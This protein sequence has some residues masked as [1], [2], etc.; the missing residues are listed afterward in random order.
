MTPRFSLRDKVLLLALA[1]AVL[2]AAAFIWF[3]R[4]QLTQD[5]GALLLSESRERITQV[6]LQLGAEL[7]RTAVKDRDAMLE[8]YSAKHGVTFRLFGRDGAQLAGPPAALPGEFR[9]HFESERARTP[10]LDSPQNLERLAEQTRGLRAKAR[11]AI[12]A[13]QAPVDPYLFVVRDPPL[14]VY[15]TGAYWVALRMP[16]RSHDDDTLDL[17]QVVLST[18]SFFGTPFFFH[19]TPWLILLA[20]VVVII[21]VCWLPLVRGVN[22]AIATLAGATSKIAKGDFSAKVD[23]RRSDELGRLGKS[24]NRMSDQLEGYVHGQKRFLRDAAHEL[25]SPLGRMQAALGNIHES[26]VSPEVH[27]LLEDLGEEIE[28][29]SS[30][31]SDLLAFAREEAAAARLHIV[32]VDLQAVA[33]RAVARENPDGVRDVRVHV[34]EGLRVLAHGESLFRGLSNAVRNAIRNAGDAGPITLR[35]ARNE[36]QTLVT[37]S[38]HGPGLP[39]EAL[40]MIFTPFYRLDDS[41]NRDTGGIGLGMSITR[42]CAE[43]CGGT[44]HCRNTHPGLE[45]IFTLQSA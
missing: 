37:V 5:L 19:L 9:A 42:T 11:A 30:L 2:I 29:M 22:G 27:R 26:P 4:T 20:M 24:L 43:N 13:G 36:G 10:L 40:E 7:P 8:R 18:S 16:I 41:R 23:I 17:G 31:T 12:E 21:L 32:P 33:R 44:V 45:V 39:E 25:R 38:D 6:A 15:D 1:N 35:A 34:D 3:S 14:I 28:H